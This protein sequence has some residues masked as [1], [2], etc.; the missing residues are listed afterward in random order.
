MGIGASVFLLAVGAILAFAVKA[1][2]FAGISIHAI[3]YILMAAGLLGLIL[4]LVIWGPRNRR[5]ETVV[6]ERVVRDPGDPR[7]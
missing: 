1:T 6:E 4:T 3:G 7:Y 5:A 2:I